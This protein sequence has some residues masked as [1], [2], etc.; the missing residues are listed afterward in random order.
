MIVV[1]DSTV[2][3][4]LIKIGEERLLQDLFGSVTVPA[5]VWDELLAFH[6][7]LPKF[8]LLRPI[9]ALPTAS[10]GK[11]L[12]GRGE[13]EAILLAQE[14][15]A[16]MLLSDDRKARGAA[17][18]A[19]IRCTGLLGMLVYAK[20]TGRMSSVKAMIEALETLGGLYLS[21]RVKTEALRLAGEQ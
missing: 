3:T 2:I 17:S 4:T 7:E 6:S 1:S 11:G 15:Q 12:L 20:Q 9:S 10:I 13:T 16:G 18:R 14:V 8:V 21:E 5:A 19:G